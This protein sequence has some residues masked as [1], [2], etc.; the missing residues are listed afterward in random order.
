M[1]TVFKNDGKL[2][3]DQFEIDP[4]ELIYHENMSIAKQYMQPT[5]KYNIFL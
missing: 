3:S 4:I 5:N 1:G 2:E